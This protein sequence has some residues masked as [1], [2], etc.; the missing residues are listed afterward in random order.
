[1][2]YVALDLSIAA[3]AGLEAFGDNPAPSWGPALWHG[4]PF[5]LGG[6]DPSAPWLVALGPGGA[7]SRSV[8]IARH[9]TW[10]IFA[11]VLV[12]APRE[13]ADTLGQA[14]AA[15]EFEFDSGPAEL[16]TIRD[17]FEIA[18][19]SAPGADPARISWGHLPFAA[20]TTERDHTPDRYSGPWGEAGG[21]LTETIHTWRAPLFLWPWR[22]PAAERR[23]ERI[24]LHA[25]GRRVLVCAVTLSELDEEP[26]PV[27]P[28][29]R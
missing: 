21:R 22:N 29:A 11:H 15:Y 6:E 19:S 26:F 3:N 13:A 16:V 14:V 24:T 25:R 18:G 5:R 28:R 1:M 10:V 23:L 4:L 9:A 27:T 7:E 17:R 12:D 2:D 8:P 20:V